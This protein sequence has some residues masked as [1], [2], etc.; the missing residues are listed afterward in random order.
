MRLSLQEKQGFLHEIIST[1]KRRRLGNSFQTVN[2]KIKSQYPARLNGDSKQEFPAVV[3]PT[4]FSHIEMLIPCA[5]GMLSGWR[6]RTKPRHSW[7]L[8]LF[9]YNRTCRDYVGLSLSCSYHLEISYR[10]GNA[11]YFTNVW[12]CVPWKSK[13]ALSKILEFGLDAASKRFSFRI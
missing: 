4:I 5:R 9:A 13:Q 7:F 11:I 6:S 8:H 10:N 2:L 3:F 12:V 1:T